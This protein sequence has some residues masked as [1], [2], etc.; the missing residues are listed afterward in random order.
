MALVRSLFRLEDLMRPGRGDAQSALGPVCITCGR[1]VDS[2]ELVEGYPGQTTFAKVLVRHHGGEE[3]RTFDMGSVEWTS[4]DLKSYMRRSN[5]FDPTAHEGL[6]MGTKIRP[7]ADF[8]GEDPAP[9]GTAFSDVK[10][11]G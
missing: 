5:W 8:A 7:D 10:K 3:L 1:V 4:E 6:G 2:E 9:K 11:A